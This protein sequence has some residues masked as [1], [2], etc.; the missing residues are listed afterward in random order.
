MLQVLQHP[1]AD[2]VLASARAKREWNDVGPC[3][4]QHEA[5]RLSAR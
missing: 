2:V 4:P 3:V 1:D 5:T